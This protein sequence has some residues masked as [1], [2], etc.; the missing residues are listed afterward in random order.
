MS[1]FAYLSDTRFLKA[2]PLGPQHRYAVAGIAWD[3]ATTNRPGARFGPRAIR[4]AS[5][6][7]CDGTH[8]WFDV[9][10]LP[11]LGDAGDLALPNTAL[12]AMRAAMATPVLR[13]VQ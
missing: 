1:S 4:Q 13:L 8:P 3:G 9:S 7:L 5:H 12:E 11:A 2:E 6:M 10:P